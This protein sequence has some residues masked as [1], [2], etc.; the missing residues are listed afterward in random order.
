MTYKCPAP[1]LQ[2]VDKKSPELYTL[3]VGKYFIRRLLYVINKNNGDLKQI[4]SK[5]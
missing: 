5:S 4:W 1:Q 2:N 3:L